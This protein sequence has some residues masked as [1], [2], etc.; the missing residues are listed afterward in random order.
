[1]SKITVDVAT[2]RAL[3]WPHVCVLC[4]NDATETLPMVLEGWSQAVRVPYCAECHGW[5]KR[6]GN[7]KDSLF[8]L[9]VIVGAIGGVL[10]L[11]GIV[12]NEG[13]A[14]LLHV[15]NTVMLFSAG[16]LVFFGVF[17][18]LLWLLLLP[19]RLIFR[20]KLASPGVKRLKSKDPLVAPIRFANSDYARRFRDA[21]GLSQS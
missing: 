5:V 8:M 14:E 10:A 7:W 18:A 4:L 17:Y 21:N 15:G 6:F 9:S 12:I 1:M 20:S 3:E 19:M 13:W 16:F 2:G 11:I